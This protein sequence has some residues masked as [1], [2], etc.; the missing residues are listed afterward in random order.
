M[1][2][3][4]WLLEMIP[5][6]T[7]FPAALFCYLPMKNQMKFTW[8]HTFFLCMGILILYIPS[9]AWLALFLNLDLNFILLPS[10]IPFF[11]LYFKTVNTDLA[12]ALTVFL[13]ACAIM[14]FPSI[15][16]YLFDACLHPESGASN[17]S[18]EAG[19]F[20]FALSMLLILLLAFPLYRYFSWMLD[21][22]NYPR[23]WYSILGLPVLVLIFNLLIVPRSYHTLHTGRILVILPLLEFILFFLLLFLHVLF[24]HTS[25]VILEHAK[26]EEEVRFLE[27]QA[28]QYQA[29]QNH[30]QQTRRLRH[31]FRHLV[32]AAAGLA[33]KGDLDCLRAQLYQYQN[34][35][36]AS[37][38]VNYCSNAALNALFNYYRQLA[39]SEHI[40]IDWKISFP[41]PLT[42]SELDLCSLLGN[43]LENAIA[44]CGTDLKQRRYFSLSIVPENTNSLY[45]VSTNSFNG[46][47]KKNHKGYLSTKRSGEG[48]GL[49]S[50]ETIA[51]KYHGS[52]QISNSDKEFF[53]NVMLKI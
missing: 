18:P 32:H 37:A 26:K 16:S 47:V 50:I 15:F 21:S 34:E 45:I 30:I 3:F 7:L 4:A 53:V 22:L 36:A 9:A 10:L 48:M 14:T 20:Q 17:F 51:K 13:D 24:Y 42:I 11:L 44:G 28:G 29:L 1:N 23:V 8:V 5:F 40:D 49:F 35:L 27:I 12:R 19:L 43:L 6:T 41:E 46:T 33:D 39:V 31:D 38:P 25:T 2:L 52:T